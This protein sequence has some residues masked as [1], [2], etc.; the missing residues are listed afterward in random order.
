MCF[1]DF[2]GIVRVGDRFWAR[3]CAL[4]VFPLEGL[5]AGGPPSRADREAGATAE[6][7]DPADGEQC[8]AVIA[9][10]TAVWNACK[11]SW[12]PWPVSPPL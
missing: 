6:G 7:C 2:V 10:N 11:K 9:A 5:A 1:S 3:P 4:D 12:N 8:V